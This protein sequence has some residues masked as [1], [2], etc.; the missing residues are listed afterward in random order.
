MN[1]ASTISKTPSASLA[2]NLVRIPNCYSKPQTQF[3]PTVTERAS[4]NGQGRRGNNDFRRSYLLAPVQS[5]QQVNQNENRCLVHFIILTLRI[6]VK[7]NC[8]QG[9]R[10]KVIGIKCAENMIALGQFYRRTFHRQFSKWWTSTIF[11][12]FSTKSDTH[13]HHRLFLK[14]HFLEANI[15]VSK[16]HQNSFLQFYIKIWQV[17]F[18][19][20]AKISKPSFVLWKWKFSNTNSID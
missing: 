4:N 8:S 20:P 7:N 17:T 2:L 14:P 6:S 1:A 9:R 13:V 19:V 18:P 11:T 15:Y 12:I 3:W 5:Y 16:Y 10:K